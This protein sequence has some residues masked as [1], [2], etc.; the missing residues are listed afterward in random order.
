MGGTVARGVRWVGLSRLGVQAVQF[1]SGLVLAR[2]LTPEEYGIIASVYVIAGFSVLF[3]DAGIGASLIYL[4]DLSE[5]DLST[6]FWL[7]V[8]GGVIYLALLAAAGPLVAA[9]FDQPS[10]VYI[11][12]LVALSFTLSVGVCHQALLE[13][14]LEFGT[15]ATLQIVSAVFGFGAS[16]ALASAGAGPVALALGPVIQSAAL[17]IG[18]W[19]RVPWRPHHGIVRSSLPRL[20]RFSGGML[21]FNSVNYWARNADNLLVG[22]VLG[23]APL[24]YYSRAYSLMLLPVHQVTQVLGRVMFPALAAMQDDH[25]RVA[26]AYRRAV[27]VI[28]LAAVPAL[29]LMAATASGLVP[30]LWGPNWDKTV[31]LL[32]VLAIAG[33]PQ[34][35]SSSVGWIYQSQGRTGAMFKMGLWTSIC[36]V[37]AMVIGLRWDAIGVAVAVLIWSWVITPVTLYVPCR[38]IGLSAGRVLLDNMPTLLIAGIAGAI[39][40]LLP[41]GLGVDREAAW[42]VGVQIVVGLAVYLIGVRAV[43]PTVVGETRALLRRQR[44]RD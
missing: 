24:G 29:V 37:G 19:A 1:L 14:E 33:V 27:R 17:S 18:L 15:V 34:C 41:A 39:V 44:D 4:R 38:M 22:K 11:A 8:L 16:I 30:L 31:P 20:W 42:V 5:E 25:D 35:M 21:G 6:A 9:F 32:Q 2:L 7:N 23:A 10:L 43:R 28:N 12:P 40:W 13:R 3:F 36:L 26:Q